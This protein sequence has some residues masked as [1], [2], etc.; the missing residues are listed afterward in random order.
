MLAQDIMIGAGLGLCALAWVCYGTAGEAT[1]NLRDR[2][3]LAAKYVVDVLFWLIMVLVVGF[4]F[5][6]Y[7]GAINEIGASIGTK[8]GAQFVDHGL[9][10]I[11]ACFGLAALYRKKD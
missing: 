8:I 7:W 5:M 6:T 4:V 1:N 11:I 2:L 9:I 3:S 10:I